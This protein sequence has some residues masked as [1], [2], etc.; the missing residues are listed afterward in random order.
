M[1]IQVSYGIVE[2]PKVSLI[3]GHVYKAKRS[4]EIFIATVMDD[5]DA[6]V[7]LE[8]GYAFYPSDLS[9]FFDITDQVSLQ[10]IKK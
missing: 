10:D 7:S 1:K 2:T 3:R 4:N 6:L 5:E 9:A 8:S